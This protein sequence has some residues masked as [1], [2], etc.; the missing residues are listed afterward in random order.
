MKLTELIAP[1]PASA[2]SND[3]EIVG[4]TAD[5]RDVQRGFMFAAL[6]G[7]KQDGRSF[8]ADAIARG[9][10]AI[11]TDEPAALALPPE[12][13]D[14]VCIITDPNPYRGLALMAARFHGRQPRTIA[15]VTGT[16]GKTSV[17][18]FTREIWTALGHPAASLGT[19]GIV[20]AAEH[21]P[22]A[23]TTPDPVALHRD[24]AGLAEQGIDHVAI[25]A[26]SHGL[27]QFRLDGMSV[28]AAAF[29]NLTRDHLDYHGDMAHYRAAKQRLFTALL[30][31][32]GSAVLNRDSAEFARL[33]GVCRDAAHPVIAYGRDPAADLRLVAREP[34]GDSQFLV[35]DV[36]GRRYELL[37]P[38]A[39]EFQVMNALA[40]LGL[41]IATGGPVAGAVDALGNLTGV[42]GRLQFVAGH[43]GG[44]AI[45]VDYA[46]TPDALATVLAALRPHAHRR[47]AVLF[48][49]G[50]DRDA[51]KR[52]LM[53]EVATRLAD[54]VYV[55]D[56][57]PR[58][59]PPAEI[60]RAI[61]DAAPNAI[62]IGDRREA[63]AT[64][65][66]ELG[67]DDLLVI[68]GKGHETGQII[69]TE[70]YPFDDAAIAHELAGKPRPSSRPRAG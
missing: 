8:A 60:R 39:G 1:V 40:A 35:L 5:S 58:T 33:G 59:E 36:F 2:E 20:T 29:T 34:R 61:L 4:L 25:E 14:R 3:P 57:N 31:P 47:L 30:V 46:H 52:P 62:E 7:T 54:R 41:V 66:A 37:L 56:D 27:N 21:R 13:H 68:A 23:L 45:V 43:D 12:E 49:C 65:I 10:V 44:G 11:L 48:G 70:T 64:A 19:L 63:I 16:N 15:A 67:A 17:V 51:G 38:L 26:S 32:C 55:T 18:H 6:P 53:G 24:L 69:G 42:P 50:G 22:G 28:A 9:A